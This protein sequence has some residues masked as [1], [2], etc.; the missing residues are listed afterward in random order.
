MTKILIIL[1]ILITNLKAVV[2]RPNE[3]NFNI[4]VLEEEAYSEK[5]IFHTMQNSYLSILDST[6]NP[7]WLVKVGEMGLDFK[8]NQNYLTYFQKDSSFWILLNDQMVEFDT[9]RCVNGLQADY[10]DMV[11][12]EDGGYILQSYHDIAMDMSQFFENGHPS[13]LVNELVLQEFD[14]DHNLI[15]EW[16]AHNHLD[17]SNYTNLNLFSSDFTWMHGNSIE[18]DY[19]NNLILSNRRSSEVIKVNRITG[20]VIWILGGP[21]NDFVFL[22]D[23]YNGFS[24]QHDVRRLENGNLLIFDNG[25]EHNPQISRIC[26]YYLDLDNMT[27]DLIWEY[28]HPQEYISLSMGSSQR[29]ENG[30]TLI[31]WGN[32]LQPG[33]VVTEVNIEKEIVMEIQFSNQY[34]IYKARKADWDFSVNLVVGDINL[35]NVV[36]IIDILITLQLI[37]NENHIETVMELYKLD[38]NLDGEVNVTDLILLVNFILNE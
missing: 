12:L 2:N 38:I 21:A 19:D 4:N 10:H 11:L 18:I 36:N 24:K 20:D 7:Y 33:T 9:L 23:S 13:A 28:V 30:N 22:N 5:L 3:F 34:K 35:D 17:I 8:V 31:S 29:L 6:L 1:L 16:Y 26:E 27:A 15:F 25:T 32:T 14:V 37:L